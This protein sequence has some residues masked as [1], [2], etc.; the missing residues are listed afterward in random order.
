MIE[1][2]INI[3]IYQMKNCR[4]NILRLG[5]KFD[6]NGE[7]HSLDKSDLEAAVAWDGSLGEERKLYKIK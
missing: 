7:T 4:T 2:H 1:I 3:S 6:W 5:L